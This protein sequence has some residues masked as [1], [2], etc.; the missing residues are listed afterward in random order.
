VDRIMVAVAIGMALV[1]AAGVI[2]GFLVTISLPSLAASAVRADRR[3]RPD[4]GFQPESEDDLILRDGS[5]GIP[6]C[7]GNADQEVRTRWKR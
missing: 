2:L 4:Y 3:V 7:D 5:Y 1:F 6:A